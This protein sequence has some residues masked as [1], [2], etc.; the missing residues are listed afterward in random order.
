MPHGG[1]GH[2]DAVP[3]GVAV[4]QRRS[5]R[6]EALAGTAT[7][8]RLA[9]R[10]DRVILPV[11]VGTL[12]LLL[13]VSV[14]SVVALYGTESERLSYATVAAGSL[15]ARAFDGPMTGTSVGAITMT[16]TFGILAILV[17]VMS[18][19][20]AVR[21]TRQEE[22]TGRTE[23]V[24]AAPVG[25]RAALTAAVVVVSLANLVL[26]VLA[27]VVLTAHGLPFAGAVAAGLGLAGVG[28]T[29]GSV[30]VVGAQLA[31]S[32][33]GANGLGAAVVGGAFGLRALGD[34][35]GEVAASGVEVISAWPSWLSPIG[36][37]QQL[38]PFADERWWIL[39]LFAATA[40]CAT[41]VA[42][43][44]AG[45]RD[46]GAGI[47]PPRPGPATASWT[48][49]SP[50]GLAFRLQRSGWAAWTAGIVLVAAAF[51]GIG[52]EAEEI[53]ATSDELVAALD[54]LGEGALTDL[55][56]GFAFGILGLAA[57]GYAIQ[58]LLRLR[59]EEVDGRAEP[60]LAAP[61][62]RVRWLTGH[63]V[64]AAVGAASALV[65]AGF[66]AGVGFAAATGDASRIVELTIAVTAQLPAVL[67]LGGF[68][69][70]VVGLVPRFA[71]G[72]AWA[73]LVVSLVVGQ[74]GALL[75]LPQAVL[76]L[77]P[78]THVPAAPAEEL[79]ATPLLVLSVTALVLAGLGAAGLRHRDVGGSSG[80]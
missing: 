38:R 20:A 21:H 46:V 28:V 60:L 31:S 65:L 22:A 34:A 70:A 7:L 26:A 30:A 33:R 2:D 23:L 35:A 32:S 63:L 8:V 13:I 77:S 52:E 64:C 76:N 48:L 72:L 39:L 69:V 71:V 61:V 16:E 37:G 66:A 75:D 50:L 53:V 58:A 9:L 40:L 25:R 43:V 41:A 12:S 51:G 14:A 36:W 17:G 54:L 44:L 27:I 56:L 67:A 42:Y 59:A 62:G 18:V 47:V 57:A 15:V 49:R 5:R 19:Q 68:V 24:G 55:F 78:F 4:V 10:R 6:E 11:W 45:R 29:F 80:T 1:G 79:T 73:G 3:P 74:L